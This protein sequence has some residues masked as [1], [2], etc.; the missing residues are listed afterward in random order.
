MSDD[1]KYALD[2]K[3]GTGR[4]MILEYKYTDVHIDLVCYGWDI[5]Y[6]LFV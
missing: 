2:T 1:G 6:F 4:A 5:T 3:H